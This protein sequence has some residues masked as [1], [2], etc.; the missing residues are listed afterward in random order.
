[1]NNSYMGCS[2]LSIV[3]EILIS[4]RNKS[5]IL[6]DYLEPIKFFLS[7]KQ[8][9]L[10]IKVLSYFPRAHTHEEKEKQRERLHNP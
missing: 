6:N 10:L 3:H 5:L 2:Q 4:E 9:Y 7:L 8:S 1:M